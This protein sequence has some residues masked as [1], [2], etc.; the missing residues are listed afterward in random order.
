[1]LTL[2]RC[3]GERIIIDGG[4]VITVVRVKDG[5]VRLGINAPR[6]IGIWREEILPKP[7]PK[8]ADPKKP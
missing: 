5:L 1:M 2:T 6:E 3:E 7:A 8:P 4:I